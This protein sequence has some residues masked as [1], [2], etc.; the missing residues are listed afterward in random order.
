MSVVDPV[1]SLAAR[2]RMAMGGTPSGVAILTTRDPDTNEPVGMVVSS[3]ISVSL[4]PPSMAVAVNQSAK[5]HSALVAH[6]KFCINLLDIQ[7]CELVPVF[8][9]AARRQERFMGSDWRTL[10]GLE[11]LE[12]AVAIFCTVSGALVCGTH[13]IFVG[14]V[15]DVQLVG[16]FDAL[17]W[18]SGRCH[19]L[20]AL[21]A[22]SG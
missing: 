8:S 13:E 15:S 21:T 11:C 22:A 18:K 10:H 9:S 2:L 17:C 19:Q 4:S 20:T 6:G 5:L 14:E 1:E 3:F 7:H 16:S 12:G